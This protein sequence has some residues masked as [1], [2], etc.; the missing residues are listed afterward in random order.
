MSKSFPKIRYITIFNFDTGK[1]SKKQFLNVFKDME[2]Q[3][4]GPR[5][6]LREDTQENKFFLVVEPQRKKNY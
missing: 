4:G 1:I 2:N 5:I 3:V 6:G